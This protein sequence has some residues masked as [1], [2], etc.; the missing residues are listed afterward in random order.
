MKIGLRIN[1]ILNLKIFKIAIQI[2][3]ILVDTTV[4]EYNYMIR[5]KNIFA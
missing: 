1:K 4:I 2:E 3:F 5:V